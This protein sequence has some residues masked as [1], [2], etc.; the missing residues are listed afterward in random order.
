MIDHE[1]DLMVQSA[2]NEW[3]PGDDVSCWE[4]SAEEKEFGIQPKLPPSPTNINRFDI[5]DLD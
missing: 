1:E 5:M 3:K 4:P 2:R